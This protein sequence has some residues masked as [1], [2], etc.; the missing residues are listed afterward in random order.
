M[1]TFPSLKDRFL[2]L[3]WTHNKAVKAEERK[4]SRSYLTLYPKIKWL[5]Y[6][7]QHEDGRFQ[8]NGSPGGD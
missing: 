7:L 8:G 3:K 6:H 5:T 1:W 2:Y 4:K